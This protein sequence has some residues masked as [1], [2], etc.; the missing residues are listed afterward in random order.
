[1]SVQELKDGIAEAVAQGD[2]AIVEEDLSRYE[3]SADQ[4]GILADGFKHLNLHKRTRNRASAP[5]DR[6]LRTFFDDVM[7]SL[8]EG[9]IPDAHRLS[10]MYNIVYNDQSLR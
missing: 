6:Q 5:S 3:L 9:Q 7:L 8:H 4:K 1:M 10:E 2:R